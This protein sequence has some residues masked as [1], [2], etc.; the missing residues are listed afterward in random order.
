MIGDREGQGL[1]TDLK[2]KAG[3]VVRAG[4]LPVV[5]L[6]AAFALGGCGGP[7]GTDASG[8]EAENREPREENERLGEEVE[9]LRGEVE[10]LQGEVEDAREASGAEA[11]EPTTAQGEEVREAEPEGSPGGGL[12]VAG[13]GEVEG[14]ELPEAMPEDFPIPAGA[15]VDYASE[16]GYNFSL[17]FVIDAGFETTTGFYDEQLSP[18]GWEETDRTEGTVEGL[19]GV[20]T[21]WERGTFIPEGSPDDPDFA[22]TKETMALEVYEIEPSGVAVE[23]FWTDFEL[24]DQGDGSG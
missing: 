17:N 2:W 21:S 3:G 1:G 4:G 14:E 10:R 9:R 16:M 5:L 18:R 7:T 13:P 12:A 15:V 20:E 19:E 24:L 22:Q 6:A 11:T 8:L 23:V